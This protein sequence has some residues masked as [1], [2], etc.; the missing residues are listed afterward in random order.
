MKYIKGRYGNPINA[1]AFWKKH[2][3]YRDGGEVRPELHDQ[4][5]WLG[6]GLNLISNQTRKPEAILNPSQWRAAEAAINLAV[7]GQGLPDQLTL[8]VDGQQFTAYVS[9]VTDARLAH[10]AD[11]LR[12]V[13][14]QYAGARR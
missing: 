13:S 2:R 4:G 12:Q 6:T 10:H 1:Q 11:G 9:G 8:S 14:R 5:G 7:Q 3:W